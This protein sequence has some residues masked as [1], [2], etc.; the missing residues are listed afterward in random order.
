MGPEGY[1]PPLTGAPTAFPP[2]LPGQDRP[3]SPGAGGK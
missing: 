3:K 1:L 2:S